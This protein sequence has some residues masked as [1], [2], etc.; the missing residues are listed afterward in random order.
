VPVDL[1]PPVHH[2]L[3]VVVVGVGALQR[4]KAGS[5]EIRGTPQ[6]PVLITKLCFLT[7]AHPEG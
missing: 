1:R 2:V 6:G 4:Q 5:V 7:L 3:G